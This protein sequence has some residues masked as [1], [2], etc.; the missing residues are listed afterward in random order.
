MEAM[1]NGALEVSC[2]N[3]GMPGTPDIDALKTL[4]AHNQYWS[5][6]STIAV[7]VA[8]LLEII[9]IFAFR[10]DR[11]RSETILSLICGLILAVG[12]Y[13]E[14]RF[15]S[16]AAR[17]NADL[18]NISDQKVAEL[19]REAAKAQLDLLQLQERVKPRRLSGEQRLKLVE[20]LTPIAKRPVR[21]GYILMDEEGRSF[22]TQIAE[23]L[24]ASGWKPGD[25][26][27]DMYPNGP[28][29]VG[30]VLMIH[31]ANAIPPHMQALSDAL[32]KIGLY[33]TS[34]TSPGVPEGMV[35]VA[36]GIKP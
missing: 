20:I 1:N 4:V 21:V 12:V 17:G 7:F 16:R 35:E 31:D 15:G 14:Y 29:P 10:K 34:G 6:W 22:A 26:V 13:G 11:P 19:N 3:S 30:V 18:Q 9:V 5:D 2:R 27:K 36:I 23:A 25:V 33:P 24:T 8:L 28:T 32:F